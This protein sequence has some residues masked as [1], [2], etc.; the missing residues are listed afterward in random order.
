M[1]SLAVSQ[2]PG[3][4]RISLG[5]WLIE[6]NL[7]VMLGLNLV[8]LCL[9]ALC[10]RLLRGV[11]QSKNL[12]RRMLTPFGATRAQKNTEKGLIAFL[13]G[14]WRHAGRLLIGSASKSDRPLINY[15]AAAHAA[16]ELGE[17]KEAE[18]HLKKA[19][20][21]TSDSELAVGIA[22]AQIQLQQNQLEQCLAT[23]LRLKKQQE[24]HPFVSKLLKTVYLRLEDWQQ[25]LNLIPTLRKHTQTNGD[26]LQS[27]EKLAWEKLFIQRTDELMQQNNLNDSA[28][29]LAVMWKK[30]PDTLCFDSSLIET[31]AKQLMR[32]NSDY[33]CEVL[34]RKVLGK[35]WDDKLV[36]LYGLVEGNN[37]SEQL[38]KAEVW[39]KQK[40]NNP[41][42][43]LTLGR[44]SLRNELWGKALEYF[45]VS[46]RILPSTEVYGE[47]NR[48]SLKLN[49]NDPA[50]LAELIASLGL[51]DLPL[52]K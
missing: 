32:L 18:Q 34:L 30:I 6:S 22:Q 16:N 10:F 19:Y 3:Y 47:I 43:L 51:P 20:D 37:F 2:D 23:L 21:N 45:K 33:E 28:E 17:I 27:L 38:T 14:D 52:P 7:W 1:L 48:L 50:L 26:E 44:L 46:A 12:F 4:V 15:L 35:Q 13:E 11:W 49:K 29:I 36:R 25:L 39:L 31:Y 24:N 42:L 8:V 5:H 9:M 41:I 40:P